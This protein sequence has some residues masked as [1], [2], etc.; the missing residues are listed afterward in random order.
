MILYI[1][2]YKFCLPYMINA[3]SSPAPDTEL[4]GE[5]LYIF[6]FLYNYLSLYNDTPLFNGGLVII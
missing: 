3:C 2:I 4:H 5:K 6:I 1:F